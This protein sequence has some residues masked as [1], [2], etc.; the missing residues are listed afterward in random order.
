MNVKVEILKS[1]YIRVCVCTE[2]AF[3]ER[4]EMGRRER[5]RERDGGVGGEDRLN[6]EICSTLQK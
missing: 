4:R 5:E 6:I 3:I 1:V 2:C